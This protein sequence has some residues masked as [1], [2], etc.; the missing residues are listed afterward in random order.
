MSILHD[1][2]RN[3][4]IEDVK[5]ALISGIDINQTDNH[6]RTALHLAAWKCN[7][8]ILSILLD[9]NVNI[10]AKAMDN[11]TALH[12]AAQNPNGSDF[13]NILIKNNKKL[14][15]ERIKQDHKTALHLAVAKGNKDVVKCLITL[16]ADILGK[17]TSG[18]TP[19]DF[20]K[21][22]DDEM[23][24]ILQLALSERRS[25]IDKAKK[26]NN[27]NGD[28]KN[29]NNNNN[30]A[31]IIPIEARIYLN[32]DD[33]DDKGDDKGDIDNNINNIQVDISTST[34]TTTTTNNDNDNDNV[35]I[36]TKRL[37]DNVDDTNDNKD[38][39]EEGEKLIIVQSGIMKKNNNKRKIILSHLEND[40]D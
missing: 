28:D 16:G 15:N 29:D 3:E 12:F 14:L 25:K 26:C 7:V 34:T 37:R 6:N 30:K 21:N 19:S 4:S 35:N 24:E 2:V 5:N 39:H 18:K 40:D 11:F 20:I 22:G 17:T 31:P 38:T 32:D 36:N 9:N 33:D 13:I 1:S 8:D 27:G 10:N 23:K